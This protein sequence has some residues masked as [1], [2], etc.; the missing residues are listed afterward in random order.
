[1]NLHFSVN[2]K[3]MISLINHLFLCDSPSVLLGCGRCDIRAWVVVQINAL[4]T[5][6]KVEGIICSCTPFPRLHGNPGNFRG[7]TEQAAESCTQICSP[8]NSGRGKIPC[9]NKTTFS[10]IVQ[11]EQLCLCL[12][13]PSL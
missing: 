1:M 12:L 13:L 11:K 5:P 3:L 7:V 8:E 9:R 10:N 4:L 6:K 2:T